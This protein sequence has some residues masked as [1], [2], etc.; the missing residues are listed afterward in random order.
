MN[1][2]TD[3]ANWEPIGF[4]LEKNEVDI[5]I[6]EIDLEYGGKVGKWHRVTQGFTSRGCA[7]APQIYKRNEYYY[8]ILAAGGTGYAH[9]VEIGR[10]KN[11]FGPYESHPSGEPIITSSPRH[12]FSLGDPDAGHFEMYNPK[13][14][15]QKAGHGSLDQTQTGEWYIAHL[16]S[17]PLEGTLL[18]PLGRETSIQKMKWTADEWLE[19]KDGSNLAKMEVEEMEGVQLSKQSSYDIFDHFDNSTYNLCFM[20]PYRNQNACWVNTN[21]R[22]GYLRIHGENSFFSQMNPAIM[23]TRATSFNYEFQTKLE[24]HPDHSFRN[25]RYGALLRFEQLDLCLFNLFRANR[26]DYF[27]FIAG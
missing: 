17:R 4:L 3:L 15:M 7:E 10:S 1:G 25:C 12:L 26:H 19:M 2:S 14:V 21:E 22:P 9:G 8:L 23:A 27:K 6:T 24:F 16:M 13:S 20:T 11:I 5:V 18:N